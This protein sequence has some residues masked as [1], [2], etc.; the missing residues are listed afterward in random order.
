MDQLK[1]SSIAPGGLGLVPLLFLVVIEALSRFIDRAVNGSLLSCF[2]VGRDAGNQRHYENFRYRYDNKENPYNQGIIRNLREI[3]FSKIPPS[4]NDF[5]A[6]VQEEENMVESTTPNLVESIANSKEKIDIE[7]GPKL[8][9]ES[10]FSIPEI[11]QNLDYDDI[12]DNFKSKEGNERIDS[13]LSLALS[14][15]QELKNF[16]QS[17]IVE[18]GTKAEEKTE[19]VGSSHQTTPPVLQV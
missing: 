6:I 11:L 16:M 9:E 18:G 2:E 4:M 13:D 15:E 7:M 14:F 5:R 1:V 17:S 3:F 8:G 10:G 19:E 12:E